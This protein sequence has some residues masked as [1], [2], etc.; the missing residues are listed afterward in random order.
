MPDYLIEVLLDED[1]DVLTTLDPTYSIEVVL[2]DAALVG[3]MPGD[4]V[5]EI[6]EPMPDPDTFVETFEFTN[7]GPLFVQG[8]VT[9]LPIS[10][11]TFSFASIAARVG[12]APTGNAAILDINKNGASVFVGPTDRPTILAGTK[13]AVVGSWSGVSLQDGDWLTVDI[14]QIGSVIPGSN[15]VVTIRLRKIA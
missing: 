5:V 11:G 15:L 10:G 2:G 12:T 7:Q 13:L 14:D 6:I 3:E 1:T 8:G 9:E 4:L